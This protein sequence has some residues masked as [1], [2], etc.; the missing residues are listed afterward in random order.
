MLRWLLLAPVAMVIDRTVDA[1]TFITPGFDCGLWDYQG[2]PTLS[3]E[4][5]GSTVKAGHH[6]KNII[7][8]GQILQAK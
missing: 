4:R 2:A 6:Q 3:D 1:G 8:M 5:G 7:T